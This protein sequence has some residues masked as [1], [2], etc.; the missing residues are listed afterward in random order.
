MDR[1]VLVVCFNQKGQCNND[2]SGFSGLGAAKKIY[3]S[4]KDISIN[5]PTTKI[6]PFPACSLS[7]TPASQRWHFAIQACWGS[8]Q[9]CS[10]EWEELGAGVLRSDSEE[11]GPSA[12]DACHSTLL[13]SDSGEDPE[14]ALSQAEL[15]EEAAEGLHALSDKLPA[16][17][18]AMLDVILLGLDDEGPRLKEFLPVLGSLKHMQAWHSAKM[19]LVTENNAGW[20]TPA[21]YL[22]ASICS[23]D[24]LLA[25]ID[26]KDLW[27]GSVLIKEKKFV[28]EL[29]FGGFCLKD[30]SVD[31]GAGV[32][33]HETDS[34]KHTDHNPQSEVFHY[35]RPALELLL[36]ITISDLPIFL[37]S[38]TEFTLELSTR[39]SKS[40]LLLDQ[41]R[42]L[43]GKVGALFSLAC[44]VSTVTVPAATQLSTQKWKEFM[45]QRPK[46]WPV[47][48]V[49]VK[50]ESVHCFLLVQGAETGGC[51]ARMIQSANQING[52]AALA[53]VN[54]LL[55]EGTLA[56]SG[57]STVD[58]LRSLP[59]LRG[60]QLM[61]RER[62]L[63]KVQMLTLKEYLR[64]KE[65]AQKPASV[66]VN[67]LRFC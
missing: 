7:G 16:P 27:R 57:M 1:Y 63:A 22:S 39:S 50:G 23:P 36:L 67:D 20:Q 62:K 46:A 48:D 61:Q 26:E 5:N 47:P 32:P 54:G 19:T 10:S 55:R 31:A 35:Y 12:V 56:L 52:A 41:L 45:A 51:T 37:Q 60:D 33:L 65:E 30:R 53:T 15:Y 64:R 42:M 6:S 28:S 34:Q 2:V 44:T 29:R 9:F 11:A 3:E 4:L 8:S 21:S 40:K 49:E 25:C 13:C 59:C 17:G 66:P 38:T 24:A 43:R 14:S 58:W 18:R